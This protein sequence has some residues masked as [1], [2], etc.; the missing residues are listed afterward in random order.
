MDKKKQKKMLQQIDEAI[1]SSK[2]TGELL[3]WFNKLKEY[4]KQ[5]DETKI[6]MHYNG[7]I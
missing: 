4:V 1:K 7:L 6:Y 5:G 3:K 2:P